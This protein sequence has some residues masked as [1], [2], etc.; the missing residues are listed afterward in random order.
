MGVVSILA[1][2]GFTAHEIEAKVV[3]A[4]TEQRPDNHITQLMDRVRSEC[5]TRIVEQRSRLSGD[6]RLTEMSLANNF[7]I[8]PFDGSV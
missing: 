4:R 5:A 8:D 6:V 3:A 7:D 2:A 1:T